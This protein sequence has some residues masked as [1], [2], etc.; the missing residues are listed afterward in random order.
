MQYLVS[1]MN[2]GHGHLRE[3][4]H[5]L[6]ELIICDKLQNDNILAPTLPGGDRTGGFMYTGERLLRK[7]EPWVFL[8]A[9]DEQ[10]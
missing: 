9:F 8:L 4:L 1:R 3:T 10:K 5:F 2:P 6:T 7:L